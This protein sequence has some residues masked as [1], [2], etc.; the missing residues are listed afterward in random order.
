MALLLCGEYMKLLI[1]KVYVF[2]IRILYAFMKMRKTQ[3][4]I[5]WLSRQSNEKSSDM[6]MLESAIR[7]MS[8]DI[9][10]V[11]RLRRLKDESAI[12]LSYILAIFG[13]MW[14]LASAKTV[15]VDTYS[16]P[17]SCLTH[18]KDTKVVQ[19]WHAMGAVKKFGLQSVGKAQ[20]RDE[21]VSKVLCMHENYDY[22]I[23]PSKRTGEI[24]TE[25]F[26]CSKE[27]IKVLSLPCVDVLLDGK[28]RRAEFVSQNPRFVGKKIVAYIP[29]FRDNDEVYAAEINEAFGGKEGIALAIS[30]HP[31]SKTAESGVFTLNGNFGSRDIMKL[32]DVIVTD[33][34]AC[35]IEGAILNKPLYFYIPDY[36]T[37]KAEKGLNTELETE[38]PEVSYR[39]A[40]SLINAIEREEYDFSNLADFRRRYV[41]NINT[42]NTERLARFILKEI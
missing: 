16:I 40:K 9:R 35:A 41:E 19:I 34:S 38:M 14:E 24:Y 36:D 25:A 21:G 13:D 3:N 2:G 10:Q 17:V 15:I 23:A 27:N 5:L 26:G 31:L 1:L 22:V 11:F 32:A 4:K 6:I 12:S 30:A 37:Y 20:G 42:D 7:E 33:Y 28:D 29:T 8:P 39:D 18:K